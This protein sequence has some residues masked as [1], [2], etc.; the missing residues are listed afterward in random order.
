MEEKI[1]D[2]LSRIERYSLLAA[3]NVLCFEDVT[4][5]TGFSKSH[6]Y[7]LTCSH[8]IPHYKPNGKQIY[9]D[10]TEIEDWMKQN[11]IATVQEIDQAATN[12]VVTG[13]MK[14]GGAV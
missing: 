12:Y 13:R 10:R 1:L 6:L 11:R 7:K 14:K 9:F 8:Q 4:L 2:Q 5:L 3:K